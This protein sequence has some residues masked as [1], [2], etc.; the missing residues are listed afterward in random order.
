MCY[1]FKFVSGDD[2]LP[3]RDDIGERRRKNE[4]RVLGRVRANTRDDDELPVDNDY[5][6]EKLNQFNNEDDNDDNHGPSESEDDFYK[7]VKRRRIE[8]LLSKEQKYSL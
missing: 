6:E 8:K 3:K 2:D 5:S 7:D 1:I 4:L